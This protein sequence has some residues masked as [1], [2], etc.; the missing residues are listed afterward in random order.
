MEDHEIGL[1]AVA[2]DEI[3]NDQHGLET[4]LATNA[5]RFNLMGRKAIV[6]T[7]TPSDMSVD[8]DSALILGLRK[9]G[10]VIL[11]EALQQRN[12]CVI[13]IMPSAN[14]LGGILGLSKARALFGE[15]P[16]IM[17]TAIPERLGVVGSDIIHQMIGK[18]GLNNIGAIKR[19]HVGQTFC[20]SINA[21]GKD[22][23]PQRAVAV[24]LG[25]RVS[26]PCFSLYFPGMV[27]AAQA[28]IG[29]AIAQGY[30]SIPDTMS[31]LGAFEVRAGTVPW[32]SQTT[33]TMAWTFHSN[34]MQVRDTFRRGLADYVDQGVCE[35]PIQMWVEGGE[36]QSFILLTVRPEFRSEVIQAIAAQCAIS[37]SFWKCLGYNTFALQISPEDFQGLKAMIE[38]EI[39]EISDNIHTG[40]F[41]VDMKRTDKED[42]EFRVHIHHAGGQS[43][44]YFQAIPSSVQAQLMIPRFAEYVD[45]KSI[46]GIFEEPEMNIPVT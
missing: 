13:A 25:E 22:P 10:K 21:S 17:I 16:A 20:T 24:V 14:E 32:D 39:C 1:T 7:A 3:V 40:T 34:E 44:T 12:I 42:D 23:V 2:F 9:D 30:Q 36:R 41:R 38:R 43:R 26:P 19:I 8:L 31:R 27:M 45:G 15:Q 5:F 29:I 33:Q 18:V 6:C 28:S 46:F 35:E 37:N 4:F 11:T